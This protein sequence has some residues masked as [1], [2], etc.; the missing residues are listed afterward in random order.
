MFCNT[1]FTIVTK[2]YMVHRILPHPLV[3]LMFLGC[4]GKWVSFFEVNCQAVLSVRLMGLGK[5]L[6]NQEISTLPT[7]SDSIVS[8]WT[9]GVGSVSKATQVCDSQ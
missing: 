3:I 4:K 5:M 8:T 1:V 6:R 2:Y 7:V 9:L